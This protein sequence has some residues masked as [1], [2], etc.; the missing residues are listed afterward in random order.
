MTDHLIF[1]NIVRFHHKNSASPSICMY[2]REIDA[3]LITHASEV[4]NILN[5]LNYK[6]DDF[7]YFFKI[8]PNINNTIVCNYDNNV[9]NLWLPIRDSWIKNWSLECK[10]L[11]YEK[12][13]YYNLMG[14]RGVKDN[15][16]ITP[17]LSDSSNT[18][19][20]YIALLLNNF[21]DGDPNYRLFVYIFFRWLLNPKM[22]NI[23]FDYSEALDDVKKM[24]KISTNLINFITNN[25]TFSCI[26]TPVISGFNVA[27][28]SLV[29]DNTSSSLS[30]RSIDITMKSFC[31]VFLN[32]VKGIQNLKKRYVAH[33]DLHYENILVQQ[34]DNGTF[35]T[36]IYDFDR[37]YS[38]MLGDNPL[39]N[40][41]VCEGLCKSGQ[42]NKYDNWL[43]FFKILYYILIGVP[44][45]F[46]ILLLNIITG[47]N[48]FDFRPFFKLIES[49]PFFIS[50]TTGCC[51]Y[52]GNNV[53]KNKIQS[54]LKNYDTIIERL[55]IYIVAP[56]PTFSFKEKS[57]YRFSLI[58]K[59]K[60]SIN[61][62]ENMIEN[63]NERKAMLRKK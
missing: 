10:A 41:N 46:K 30:K 24:P 5:T 14:V 16:T 31:I 11:E 19:I 51:W 15:Y 7:K 55:N 35:N 63:N 2:S 61:E 23:G 28:F 29:I 39:L 49:S 6:K 40:N 4:S 48:D 1:N 26:I 53:I 60:E 57:R 9:N 33:N 21:K 38:P 22:P 20:P 27:P 56:E 18:T 59:N 58:D 54:L 25:L 47:T 34:L 50:P 3:S 32:I 44:L 12:E 43:D 42:C 37:S 52:W 8:W 36:F 13:V 62:F 45:N 17:M